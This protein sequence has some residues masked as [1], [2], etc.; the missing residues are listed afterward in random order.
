MNQA[1]GGSASGLTGLDP[2]LCICS[3]AQAQ[4]WEFEYTKGD[5]A[6]EIT[7]CNA[8]IEYRDSVLTARLYGE[9]LDF[10]FYKDTFAIPNN[11]PL[12]K[13]VFIFKDKPFVL[14]AYA[15]GPE[16]SDTTSSMFLTPQKSDF[17]GLLNSIRYGSNM[18][19]I[20]PD[21]TN[22]EV[23]LVGSEKAL[24]SVAACW[25]DNPTGAAGVNPFKNSSGDNPFQ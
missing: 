14:D 10:F 2:S 23:S 16:G 8:R 19:I 25:I 7:S 13:V 20:F 17:S 21:G 5:T 12:G 3:T 18:G 22:F 1:A 4:E 15:I 11:T 24:A 6:N 9:D